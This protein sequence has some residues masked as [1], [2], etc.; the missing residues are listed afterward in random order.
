M[1]SLVRG[2][3]RIVPGEPPGAREGF[4][5]VAPRLIWLWM[6]LAVGTGPQLL[7]FASVKYIRN[8]N[9]FQIRAWGLCR[10][11]W[12]GDKGAGDAVPV[13][14]AL[15]ASP[16]PR[17]LKHSPL[18][19]DGKRVNQRDLQQPL[20]V[21]GTSGGSQAVPA[22]GPDP[23]PHLGVLPAPSP[24]QQGQE[25]LKASQVSGAASPGCYIPAP[26]CFPPCASCSALG[27]GLG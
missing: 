22:T 23:A 11:S 3:A 18:I 27:A 20:A 15:S 12:G 4:F 21:A 25:L 10:G 6:P 24:Q 2:G 7:S 16:L 26:R 13:P 19:T 8:Q 5:A 17:L 9:K 14:G 1:G